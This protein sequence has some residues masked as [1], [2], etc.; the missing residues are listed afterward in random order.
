MKTRISKIVCLLALSSVF[1]ATAQHSIKGTV[2]N[3]EGKSIPEVKVGILKTYSGTYSNEDGEYLLNNINQDTVQLRFSLIGYED[4]QVQ[5]VFSKNEEE[6]NIVLK[7]SARMIEEVQIS[8][9]RADNTTPTTY[10]NLSKEEIQK[11]NF[12]QDIPYLMQKTPSTV[13]TS[14]A[15]A[16][17]GYTGIRIRG[18]DPTRTNVTIN[19]IP[20]ND[21]E[22]H[23][24][25]WVNMPDFA[26]STDNIQIQRGVGTSTNGAAA[27][28]SSINIKTDNIQKEAYASLDNSV[29]SFNTLKNNIKV[30]T[31]LIKNQFTFD[32]RVSRIESDGY[33]DRASSNLN[34]MYLSGAWIGKKTLIKANLFRGHERTYQAWYGVSQDQLENDRTFNY[35]TYD[36]EVDNYNQDHYQLHLTQTINSKMN[37]NVSGH[38]TKGYGYYEQ[39]RNDDDFSTYGLEPVILTNDTINTTDLI[40]R[41]WLDNDFYGAVFSLNYSNLKNLKLVWGGAINEYKGKHFGEIIWARSASQ[42]EIRDNYYENDAQKNEMSSYIRGNYKYKKL[43]TYLD[44]QV[45]HIDYS[46]L[47]FDES[48]GEIIELQQDINFTFFNP[49]AGL[50][51]TF[52]DK[53]N[54]YGSYSVANREPVRNDFVNSTPQSRPKAENLQNVEIGYRYHS[55]KLFVNTN[56]YLMNYKDQLILS[57]EINDVGAYNRINVD[58]SH[59]M[60]VELEFGYMLTKKLSL[61]GNLTLSSNKIKEF[62]EYVDNYD[63]Y[64]TEGNMIQDVINHKNTD[65]AFSPNTIASLGLLYEPI[66]NLELGLMSKYVGKQYLDN[67]SNE[68]RKLN[69]YYLTN[70]TLNYTFKNLGFKELKI[71][72]LVNNVFD[73][74]YENNGYTFSYVSGGESTT[75]NFYYPQAGRNFLARITLNF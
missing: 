29:G 3:E 69:E 37:F 6:K 9:V 65:I 19:G 32:A 20:L 10:T 46:Y 55:K 5:I 36:N 40:R 38:Y 16:G 7:P 52:N 66:K 34:S 35:Y 70:L 12:G 42:S 63:N 28:G 41:R 58:Q 68:N 22:S 57:G 53:S 39:Y 18:V 27:F 61:S 54:V 24:V 50:T 62:D 11:G 23:G 43:N 26:S 17:V 33:I 2:T 15:G 21:A 1:Q 75:E 49:K 56:Y 59:R 44:L 67:T 13:V 64:D 14:D 74:L 47:G 51:Y 4:Q 25:Y 45:R 72:V 48:F 30:G 60:G 73:Y 31:G 8:A 71:G